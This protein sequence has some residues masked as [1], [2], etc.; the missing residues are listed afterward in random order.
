MGVFSG[1][2]GALVSDCVF[3]I[4]SRMLSARH[5]VGPAVRLAGDHSHLWN[6]GLGVCEEEFHAVLN[7]AVVLFVLSG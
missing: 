5:V 3:K 2:I 1:T 7:D 4:A 6:G